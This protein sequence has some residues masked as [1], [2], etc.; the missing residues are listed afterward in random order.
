MLHSQR[1][2]RNLKK[3]PQL[4]FMKV[5]AF[6]AKRFQRIRR[7]WNEEETKEEKKRVFLSQLGVGVTV[8]EPKEFVEI[9]VEASQSLRQKFD[10]D[11]AAPFFS[12][13]VLK[14]HLDPAEAAA[15]ACQLVSRVQ[16]HIESVHCS[17]IA[18]LALET[19]SIEV[20]GIGCVKQRIPVIRFIEELGLSFSYLTA[21]SYVWMHD[22]V[23]FNAMEMYIDA[24][25]SK[26]TKAWDVVKSKGPLKIFY[27]GD[28]CNPFISCADIIAFHLD[29]L[30]AAKK[31][32]LFP[33]KVKQVFNHYKFDTT[34]WFFDSSSR[35]YYRWQTDQTIDLSSRLARPAIFLSID[36]FTTVGSRGQEND[37]QAS[38]DEMTAGKPR[39][40]DFALRQS[41]AYQAV[42]KYAYQKNGCV[43]LFNPNEDKG[44]VKSGDVFV[45]AGPD[46]ERISKILQDMVD[47]RVYSGRQLADLV[48]K[49]SKDAA[50]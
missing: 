35:N 27:R 33:D 1:D 5:V 13:T 25:R 48:N 4:A 41:P 39:K 46:S 40:Y 38:L 26:R 28:E 6:D 14:H 2:D 36:Q 16:D 50:E 12:S 49:A 45:Y 10:L 21:L 24:F 3:R 37:V 34:S 8:P 9:Y 44:N 17:Y 15:F 29:E 18:P 22:D 30:L 43:K 23:D 11:Y 19:P 47:I 32:K 20:G 31:L 7:N 42:L